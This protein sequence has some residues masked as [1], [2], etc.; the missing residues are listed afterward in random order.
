MGTGEQDSREDS[1]SFKKVLVWR[2]LCATRR[3][4]GR[5]ASGSA[6]GSSFRRAFA[7][8]HGC[9]PSALVSLNP[10]W[11]GASRGRAKGK[12]DFLDAIPS[13]GV[14]Y[15]YL[16][17]VEFD[18]YYPKLYSLN[19]IIKFMKLL[20]HNCIQQIATNILVV[21]F[22]LYSKPIQ[23]D[24]FGRIVFRLRRECSTLSASGN[25]KL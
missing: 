23:A 18:K 25:F 20:R 13:S 16:N 3:A 19:R 14:F 8:S 7:A 12:V 21:G 22:G 17:L 5:G 6:K 1:I 9:V 4:G 24:L 10:G 11:T 2:N 15:F